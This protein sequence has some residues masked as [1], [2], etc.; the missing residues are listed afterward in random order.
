[1]LKLTSSLIFLCVIFNLYLAAW[2]QPRT[3]LHSLPICFSLAFWAMTLQTSATLPVCPFLQC[4]LVCRFAAVD[5][6]FN[7]HV[8]Q[9]T[10]CWTFPR[11]TL[12]RSQSIYFLGALQV[13]IVSTTHQV[14]SSRITYSLDLSLSSA[15][16]LVVPSL[17]Y[18]LMPGS[19]ADLRPQWSTGLGF[20]GPTKKPARY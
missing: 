13:C 16:Q 1:M 3:S 9:T 17:W 15:G 11:G 18:F 6:L 19:E 7:Q 8:M 4:S 14:M 5:S 10:S 12:E 2:Y 20:D